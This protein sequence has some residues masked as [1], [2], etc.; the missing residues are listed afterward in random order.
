M[1]IKKTAITPVK[2]IIQWFILVS[3]Y[4]NNEIRIKIKNKMAQK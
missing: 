4:N 2:G 3:E 1:V